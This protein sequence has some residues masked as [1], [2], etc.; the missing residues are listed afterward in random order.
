MSF[1]GLYGWGELFLRWKRGQ[2]TRLSII[3][4]RDRISIFD[5]PKNPA[6]I[7]FSIVDKTSNFIFKDIRMFIESYWNC[8]KWVFFYNTL[9]FTSEETLLSRIIEISLLRRSGKPFS[10]HMMV[11]LQDIIE[12]WMRFYVC[13]HQK[14]K[15]W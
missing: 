4:A 15:S 12:F 10:L 13:N 14:S 9:V 5:F 3:Q 2:E 8:R 6:K 11:N 7:A 1:S